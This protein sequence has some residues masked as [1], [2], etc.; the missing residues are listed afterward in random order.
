MKVQGAFGVGAVVVGPLGSF[1]YRKKV[2]FQ[3]RNPSFRSDIQIGTIS[4][5]IITCFCLNTDVVAAGVVVS[6]TFLRGTTITRLAN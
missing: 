1:V 3:S 4:K 6:H 5:N 2:P